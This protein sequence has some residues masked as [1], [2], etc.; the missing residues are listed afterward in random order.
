MQS[1]VVAQKKFEKMLQGMKDQLN[2]EVA[3]MLAAAADWNPAMGVQAFFLYNCKGC[4][5]ATVSPGAAV[6]LADGTS[7][8]TDVPLELSAAS[9]QASEVRGYLALLRR[10]VTELEAEPYRRETLRG[11]IAPEVGPSDFGAIIDAGEVAERQCLAR[12][13]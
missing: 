13:S 7:Y 6:V 5:R 12:A 9:S 1:R 3:D 10:F 8:R 4:M 2:V 11:L